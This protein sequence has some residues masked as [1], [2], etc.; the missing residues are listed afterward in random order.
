MNLD[1]GMLQPYGILISCVLRD[2]LPRHPSNYEGEFELYV[3]RPECTV[4]FQATER[5]AIELSQEW[6]SHIAEI[7]KLRPLKSEQLRQYYSERYIIKF[8]NIDPNKLLKLVL[9]DNVE[10]IA[11]LIRDS[12]GPITGENLR[13]DQSGSNRGWNMAILTLFDLSLD[14]APSNN[15]DLLLG[16]RADA[17]SEFRKALGQ[18]TEGFLVEP[19]SFESLVFTKGPTRGSLLGLGSGIAPQWFAAGHCF[20]YAL[21]G[22]GVG[23][24]C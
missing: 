8:T 18:N 12:G 20:Q 19:S 1:H 15:A 9:S 17:I 4:G 22:D 10:S 6:S 5:L 21:R 3:G 23:R 2:A 13:S 16:H 11:S 14:A 7:F 24:P